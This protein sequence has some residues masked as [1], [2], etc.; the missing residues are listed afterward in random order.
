M[1]QYGHSLSRIWVVSHSLSRKGDYG[2]EIII[3]KEYKNL[4]GFWE[5]ETWIKWSRKCPNK[6][7]LSRI[8]TQ[9]YFLSLGRVRYDL[10]EIWIHKNH[11]LG[12][13]MCL[14]CMEGT[15]GTF[16]THLPIKWVLTHLERERGSR[17]VKR[18]R[19]GG[20][21]KKR[22]CRGVPWSPWAPP[23]PST[24]KSSPRLHSTA[25]RT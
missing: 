25:S 3:D 10:E 21:S 4:Y 13:G 6:L 20:V 24:H 14:L 2:G 8:R 19:R 16:S 7:S 1:S 11:L 17:F 9:N 23:S 18:G 22:G 15:L 12:I 5:Q